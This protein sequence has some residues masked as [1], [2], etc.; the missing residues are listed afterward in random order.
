M[1]LGL[2]TYQLAQDW[3]LDRILE[4][5]PAHGFEGVELRA[6]HAHGVEVDLSAEERAEVRK[7]FEDS[8]LALVQL[9]SAFEYHSDDPDELRRNIE[10]TKEYAQLAADIGAP[11][12][13]VRPNRLMVDKG[14]PEEETLK[15]MGESIAEC[16]EHAA[17]LG[18]EIRVEVHGHGTQKPSRIR[19]ILDHADHPNVFA[20][21]NS[22]AGEVEDGSIRA[23]FDLL[24]PDIAHVHMRDLCAD[25]YP[26][27]DLL[28]LLRG[29]DY[30]GYCCAEIPASEQPGRIMDY[31]R[32]VWDAYHHILDM[33]QA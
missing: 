6:T 32:T 4:M 7:R 5:C 21:W 15:Q 10:G 11:G 30:E 3:D 33:E 28:R 20:N 19:T 16:A 27:L 23:N 1:K 12:I 31:Y 25:D 29:I 17:D 26:W 9:G 24:A 13:K 18:V 2:V 8:P 14:I 22:N